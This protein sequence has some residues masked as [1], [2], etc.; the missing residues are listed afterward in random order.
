[1]KPSNQYYVGQSIILTTLDS[2]TSYSCRIVSSSEYLIDISVP[3]LQ[4]KMVIWPVGTKLKASIADHQGELSFQTEILGRNFEGTR[5]YTIM[6]PHTISR[7][8]TGN[9]EHS[10]TRVIAVTS[11]KGGVG[12]TT[13]VINLAIA[14]ANLGKRVYILD[15][16]LGTAD[17]DVLL[18]VKSRYNI[19]DLFN[20]EK[21]LLDIA[22]AAPGNI[23]IIPGSSG[24][25]ELTH[26][27]DRQ[28]AQ[29]ISTFNQLD[30]VSD[31]ILLDTGAG[32]STDVSN[33]LLASD[34]VIVITTPE[35]HAMM[36]AY[37]I[38]KVMHINGC[39]AKQMLIVNRAESADDANLVAERLLAVVTHYLK[40]DVRYLG[41]VLD[42]K[43]VNRSVRDQNPLLLSHPDSKPAEN[44][45]RIAACLISK[46]YQSK[47]AGVTGFITKLYWSFKENKKRLGL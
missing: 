43:L 36:D 12:K 15:L 39:L 10:K 30:G 26:L 46:P 9:R 27:K 37:A 2:S 25:Q 5:S 28:F 11:G 40:K 14:L 22:V 4:G 7:V 17:V 23:F 29:V 32:I 8:N 33:F 31:I 19:V 13:L 44:I 34:E 6:M 41:Y 42:D 35:P 38:L 1:M 47:A 24:V 3:Y 16:D 45:R 21:S 20:G 18:S